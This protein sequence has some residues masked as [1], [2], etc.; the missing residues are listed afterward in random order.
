MPDILELLIAERDSLNEAIAILGGPRRRGRPPK[1]R[2][3][4]AG[5]EEN[6]ATASAKKTGN[7]R[8][9]A[10]RKALSRALKK[11]WA[12]RRKAATG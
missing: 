5:M 2:K 3:K 4:T 10:H 11:Y 12:S 6:P 9:V 1:S 8:S 7:T